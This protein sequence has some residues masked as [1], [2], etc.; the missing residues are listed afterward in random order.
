MI[1]SSIQF[2]AHSLTVPLYD[3]QVTASGLPDVV[4]CA[5]EFIDFLLI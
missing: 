3:A 4:T 1:S 2:P 5:G